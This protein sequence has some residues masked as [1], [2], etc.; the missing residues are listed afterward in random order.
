MDIRMI[1]V[2]LDGTLFR[3]DKTVSDRTITA[4]KKCRDKGIKVIY[5]TARGHSAEQLV[6]G[7]LFDGSVRMNGAA[8]YT[9]NKLVYRRL[10]ATVDIKDLL[11]AA[12]EAE[13]QISVE[14]DG[15]NYSN[16]HFPDEWG[17]IFLNRNEITDFKTLEIEAEKI[18]AMPKSEVEIGLLKEHLPKEVKL[19]TT[20]DDYFTMIIHEEAGKSNAILALAEYWDININAI[21]TFGDDVNDLDMLE[22]CGIGIA[23]GNAIDEVKAIADYICDTNEN[24]GIAKWLEEFVVL[25]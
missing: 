19:I 8:A 25:M 20:R 4:L 21:I 7:D 24:D 13:I 16:F 1:A 11:I 10:I 9:G 2:D 5:A 22:Y 3:D 15:Q 18:W 14:L 12:N 6:P 23:M 17:P